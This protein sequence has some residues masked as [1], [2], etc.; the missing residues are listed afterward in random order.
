M[1]AAQ[2]AAF[3]SYAHEDNE[4]DGGGI[5]EL[6]ENLRREFALTT[7]E[8]LTLFID[9]T[10]IEWGD[11]WRRRIDNALTETTFFIPIVTP[12]Y[13]TRSECRREL[14]DF[15]AQA[16]SLGMSELILPIQYAKIGDFSEQNPDEAVALVARMQRVEWAQLRLAGSRSPEYRAAVNSLAVRLADLSNAI[17]EAQLSEELADAENS[18]GSEP[19][20]MELFDQINQIFPEWKQ[21]LEDYEVL[22]A[23]I[24]ATLRVHIA[25]IEKMERSSPASARFSML[26][27]LAIDQ[28]PLAEK[29]LKL[30]QAYAAKTIEL[31]PLILAALRMG[32]TSSSARTLFSDTYSAITE[33]YSRFS[34]EEELTEKGIYTLASEWTMKRAHISRAIGQL[35]HIYS[36]CDRAVY[37]ANL[38]FIK[39][40]EEVKQL[41][42]SPTGNDGQ[43]SASEEASPSP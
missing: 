40:G 12:R 19:G 5:V 42:S 26:Q 28:L 3:W 30:C 39:W 7:G 15:S 34:R 25:R 20:L 6:A 8:D 4:L 14:L 27:R 29:A 24:Q 10:A 37:E 35:G 38:I 33:A 11:E 1:T 36:L 31:D 32:Q 22:D 23:Q 16:K 17:A 2:V 9:R 21:S 43:S 18:R 13:F 41:E